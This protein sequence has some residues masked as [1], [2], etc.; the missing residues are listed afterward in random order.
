M[1]S[2]KHD[3]S[4]ENCIK[5]AVRVR[6][7]NQ[8]E[9]DLES[10]NIINMNINQGC[11]NQTIITNPEDGDTKTFGFDHCFWSFNK[12][13]DNVPFANQKDVYTTIGVPIIK[14]AEKGYN[15][16]VLMYGQ[17]GSGK[18]HTIM[19]NKEDQGLIPRICNSLFD[20]AKTNN[21]K[22][23]KTRIEASYLE[24]YS[25]KIYDLLDTSNRKGKKKDLHIRHTIA[26]GPYVEDLEIV[27]VENYTEMKRLMDKGNKSRSI[28]ST[29]M[30]DRSS[31]S[32]AVFTIYLTQLIKEEVEDAKGKTTKT[33]E[34]SSKINLVDLAGSER[35]DASGVEGIHFK[36]AININKSLSTLGN[37]IMKLIAKQEA[38][39][40]QAKKEKK[41]QKKNQKKHR[42]NAKSEITKL[43]TIDEI[44]N[45]KFNS[46][47]RSRLAS[48]G[49]TPRYR[50]KRLSKNSKTPQPKPLNINKVKVRQKKTGSLER[51]VRPRNQSLDTNKIHIPFRDSVL[52]WLLQESLGGNSKSVMIA[53]I[54]PS[55][56]NYN[57]TLNTLKYASTAKKIV[58]K[59]KVNEDP[60]DRIVRVLREEID[61]LKN[62]LNN[63]ESKPKSKDPAINNKD[64]AELL[65]TK[66]KLHEL[67]D[68]LQE[69]EEALR[70]KE[71]TWEEKLKK[72]KEFQNKI[73]KELKQ[74]FEAKQNEYLEKQR[75]IENEKKELANEIQELKKDLS[76]QIEMPKLTSDQMER[77]IQLETDNI[78]KD[79][80]I[81]KLKHENENLKQNNKKLKEDS[82]KLKEYEK[83]DE[84]NKLKI[85]Q[86]NK[87]LENAK[88]YEETLKFI[89]NDNKNLYELVNNLRGTNK[90]QLLEF[91]QK[92][93]EN[94]ILA[95]K[96]KQLKN[97]SKENAQKLSKF[98]NILNQFK[99]EKD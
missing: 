43:E 24:I 91:R 90:Q 14:N 97:R 36:E 2:S 13:T 83:R 45:T 80:E 73:I 96:Y 63:M 82:E 6:P 92:M 77:M 62:K 49:D 17:T 11:Q 33:R 41:N 75:K 51:A 38:E 44:Q 56:I 78:K 84:L 94:M 23:I 81:L 16:C 12:T 48:L 65:K 32:H 72:S 87:D 19:G 34:I 22:G 50:K 70:N 99:D 37:V 21:A 42:K 29:K 58:N 98:K 85:E 39:R 59:A 55:D 3:D 71:K 46:K 5:V 9:I 69:R 8:R 66:Q 47:S 93:K 4:G 95:M 18:T 76:V 74:S 86:L 67:Q 61:D 89:T 54:S 25:E 35:V 52:T 57:E 68:E 28:A 20:K 26:K 88:K 27:M 40:K 15:C 7:F 1:N 60:N 10:Q 30:N 31:R 64:M 53:T 79:N